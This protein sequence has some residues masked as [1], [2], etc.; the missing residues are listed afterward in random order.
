MQSQYSDWLAAEK[1]AGRG[2]EVWDK[3]IVRGLPFE[4]SLLFPVDVSGDS[5]RASLAGAPD[6]AALVTLTAGAGVTVGAFTDDQTSVTLAL[7]QGQVD[8]ITS[9]QND[10]D[11]DGLAEVLVDIH[12]QEGSAGSWRRSGVFSIPISGV[13]AA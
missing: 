8:T 9:A 5:F 12:W 4:M 13:I 2:G 11:S 10:A 1:R 6:A 3:P 7:T